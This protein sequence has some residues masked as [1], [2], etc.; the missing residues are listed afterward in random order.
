MATEKD[1]LFKLL[2]DERLKDDE[3][4]AFEGMQSFLNG[5][6]DRKLSRKQAEWVKDRYEKLELDSDDAMNLF[7]SGKVPRGK[8]VPPPFDISKRPL[9]P[10]GRKP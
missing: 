8:E 6:S 5:G 4:E 1:M 7:S 10:P 9:R 2:K 3:R